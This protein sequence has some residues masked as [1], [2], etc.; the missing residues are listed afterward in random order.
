[1]KRLFDSIAVGIFVL[2]A[3]SWSCGQNGPSPAS[4]ALVWTQ[5]DSI[6]VL[7]ATSN[8]VYRGATAGNYT[9][10]ALYC[11]TTPITTYTDLTV[12]AGTTYHWAVTARD[13]AGKE[14]QYSNDFVATIPPNPDAPSG[15]N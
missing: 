15:L 11:S 14:S 5:S 13:A 8:C 2:F 3:T 4:Q 7:A 1:M 9:L 10:P 12:V 6:G